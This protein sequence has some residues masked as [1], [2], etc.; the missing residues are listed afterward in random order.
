MEQET[1]LRTLSALLMLVLFVIFNTLMNLLGYYRQWF[2]VATY[3]V[4]LVCLA[5]AL[6]YQRRLTV[7]ALAALL[8]VPFAVALVVLAVRGS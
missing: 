6:R 4:E 2:A 8:L 3:S 1:H 5:L 7:V